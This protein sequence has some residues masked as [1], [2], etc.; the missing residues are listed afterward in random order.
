MIEAMSLINIEFNYLLLDFS[1]HLI[2]I[3]KHNLH[4]NA[5]RNF[6]LI[7]EELNEWREFHHDINKVSGHC[8]TFSE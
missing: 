6:K 1:Q 5:L 2:M 7:Q 3:I 4:E 8:S